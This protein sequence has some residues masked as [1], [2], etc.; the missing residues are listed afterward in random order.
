M[1]FGLCSD[2][3][4][5]QKEPQHEADFMVFKHVNEPDINALLNIH[6]NYMGKRIKVGS[7][8]MSVNG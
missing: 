5:Q 3:A 7:V 8:N 4:K 1:R 6:V 2:S